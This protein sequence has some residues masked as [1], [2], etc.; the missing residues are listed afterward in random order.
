MGNLVLVTFKAAKH[1]AEATMFLEYLMK[2][3]NYVR[4]LL[5]DPASY[6]PVTTA[7]IR[8][9]PIA[10]VHRLKLFRASSLRCKPNCR[11][12]GSMECQIPM[13]GKWKG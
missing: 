7:A 4:F 1:K 6:G 11:T 10:I 9:P 5:T 2:N 13:P 12:P 8:I 3:E